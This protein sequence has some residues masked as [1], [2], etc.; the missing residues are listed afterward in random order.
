MLSKVSAARKCLAS[1]V[2]MIIGPG[3]ERDVLLRLFH[4]EPIGTLFLPHERQYHGMKLWLANL[5]KPAGDLQLDEGAVAALRKRG[6]SLL[7]IGVRKVIGTFGVGAAVRCV[8][9]KGDLVGVGLTNYKSTEIELIRGHRS[10]EIESI[11]GYKH[12]DEVIHRNNFVLMGEIPEAA[13]GE[14][15]A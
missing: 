13:E 1:G 2:A 4:G 14:M 15:N 12:S 6:K 7:P 9:E 10:E 11:I 5:P 3:R 8:D